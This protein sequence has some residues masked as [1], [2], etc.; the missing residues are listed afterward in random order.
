MI[1]LL[2]SNIISIPKDNRGSIYY[3]D[4]RDISLSNSRSIYKMYA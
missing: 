1:F 2:L 3:S 4:S